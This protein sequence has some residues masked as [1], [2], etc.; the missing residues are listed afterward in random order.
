MDFIC[1][2]ACNRALLFSFY[3]LAISIY[4]VM[5]NFRFILLWITKLTRSFFLAY[6]FFFS[7]NVFF[8]LCS[9]YSWYILITHYLFFLNYW[10]FI[11][12]KNRSLFYENACWNA[13][14]YFF[15]Y[16]FHRIVQSDYAN[17]FNLTPFLI[18]Y[19]SISIAF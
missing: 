12:S 3:L 1:A 9:F 19:I 10:L 14:Y 11:Y 15:Y 7:E 4:I 16:Y 6:V 5:N 2:S 18:V 13:I 8:S 17:Y